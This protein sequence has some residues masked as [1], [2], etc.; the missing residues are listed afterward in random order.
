MRTLNVGRRGMV[1]DLDK[2]KVMKVM[3]ERRMHAL[4][5]TEHWRG[6]DERMRRE[7]K[8]EETEEDIE[9]RES[10]FGDKF[11]WL[12]RCRRKGGKGGVGLA[13]LKEW[14]KGVVVDELSSES[15][16][17]VRIEMVQGGVMYVAVV[18]LVPGGSV[19]EE[20]VQVGVRGLLCGLARYRGGDMVETVVVMG[21]VNAR[22][23]NM[24]VR[25]ERGEDIEV[26]ARDSDDKVVNERGTMLMGLL[27]SYGMVVMNGVAG[28]E[29]G[30]ATCRGK[31]VVDWIAVGDEMKDDCERLVVDEP[32]MD[33]YENDG[34]D[35]HRMVRID[36]LS[37]GG[38]NDDGNGHH[39]GGD[40]RCLGDG[41]GEDDESIGGGGGAVAFRGVDDDRE[42]E[43]EC[44]GVTEKANMGIYDGV[45]RVNGG[46]GDVLRRCNLAKGWRD[47]WK[48]VRK[49]SDAWMREWCETEDMQSDENVERSLEG[50]KK[51]YGRVVDESLHWMKKRKGK[52]KR[53]YDKEVTKWTRMMEKVMEEYAQE[54]DED[55]KE[56]LGDQ[57]KK[58][59]A[60]RQRMIRRGR[61]KMMMKRMHDMENAK[62]RGGGESLMRR[63]QSWSGKEK[64]A[65]GGDRSKM[66]G[67][68]GEWIEGDEM[69]M[70]WRESF[71]T[72]GKKLEEMGGFDEEWKQNVEHELLVA[73]E[74]DEM[75]EEEVSMLDGDAMRSVMMDGDIARWEVNRVLRQ[76]HNGKAVGVDG[77]V[78]EV[79]KYGGEWMAESVWR[80]CGAVFRRE[81]VPAEWMK[82]SRCRCGRKAEG[83]SLVTTGG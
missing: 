59:R 80:L 36:W 51:A 65:G 68:N 79:L 76:L 62:V 42:M 43:R 19:F 55:K 22:I 10:L 30:R 8:Q 64:K 40:D 27:Q 53:W 21:D 63:L 26:I 14:G 6:R 9:E 33:E 50:W 35:D 15:V 44:G 75:R 45:D 46:G 83:R 73:D 81:G 60:E 13:V 32:W 74:K 56:E 7:L 38:C 48:G 24:S 23:G 29:S 37:S 77:V 71:E 31:S 49:G 2:V 72:I 52:K 25:I 70:K 17:W 82:R 4:G 66:R 57:K 34:V 1:R 69:R 61:S 47:G 3:K 11:Q 54:T 41:D 12:E 58:M 18:Y 78:A 5:V 39:D 67:E 28:K 20:E 16:M